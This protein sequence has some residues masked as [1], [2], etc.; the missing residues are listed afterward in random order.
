MLGRNR[1]PNSYGKTGKNLNLHRAFNASDTSQ[2]RLWRSMVLDK[3]L[4]E[5]PETENEN[6]A[7]M[8]TFVGVRELFEPQR[9][10]SFLHRLSALPSI[11]TPELFRKFARLPK[12]PT[13]EEERNVAYST[14][15]SDDNLDGDKVVEELL[16]I[17]YFESKTSDQF[18]DVSDGLGERNG[19]TRSDVS[20][21]K[22]EVSEN[23]YAI[24]NRLKAVVKNWKNDKAFTLSSNDSWTLKKEFH[25]DTSSEEN[26]VKNSDNETDESRETHTISIEEDKNPL[27][28]YYPERAINQDVPIRKRLRESW[29]RDQRVQTIS[30]SLT[31]NQI[32]SQGPRAWT[33]SSSFHGQNH[34]L[35]HPDDLL[36]M[37]RSDESFK[38]ATTDDKIDESHE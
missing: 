11:Q 13:R 14:A 17:V 1:N 22:D 5:D 27:D 26:S 21:Q 18:N 7:K 36:M 4:T 30:G 19:T 20:E 35:P 34:L 32:Y 31:D 12:L 38:V 29:K 8:G 2:S 24:S 23:K 37:Q 15:G 28:I 16:N 6:S 9:R 25:T 33:L 3:K 10:A